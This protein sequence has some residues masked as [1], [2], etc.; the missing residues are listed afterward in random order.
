M[1]KIFTLGVSNIF[2]KKYTSP[3]RNKIDNG[4]QSDEFIKSLPSFK[5]NIKQKT[6]EIIVKNTT[7]LFAAATCAAGVLTT[8]IVNTNKLPEKKQTKSNGVKELTDK[9]PL[10]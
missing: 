2:P 6:T 3:S 7:E 4:L 5:A 8:N 10:E 1:N 9:Y